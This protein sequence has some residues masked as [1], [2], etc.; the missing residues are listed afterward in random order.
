MQK[1]NFINNINQYRDFIHIDDV[2]RS[3]KILLNKRFEKPINLSSGEKTNLVVACKILNKH[4]LNRNI[5]FDTKIG[6]DIF[7][8]NSIL[9]S[10]G[11]KK[12][13]TVTK[14]LLSYK[15]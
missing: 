12:F 9:K 1:D 14:T 11:M 3:I 7:G 10:I 4:F 2:S 8:D 15:K 6:E 5:F 13:K